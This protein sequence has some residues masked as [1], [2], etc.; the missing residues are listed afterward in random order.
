MLL[1]SVAHFSPARSI[2]ASILIAIGIGTLLLKLPFCHAGI[3]WINALF[4]ATSCLCIC[5]LSTVPFASFTSI[6]QCVLLM[7][8]QIGGLGLVTLT[9][10]LMSI[11]VNFGFTTQVIAGQLMELESWKD[12]KKFIFFIIGFTL[13]IEL[14]GAVGT[15]MSIYGDYSLPR[16]LFLSLFHAVSTFC[17]AGISLFPHGMITY[18]TH[19]IMLLFDS[20]IMIIAGLGFI[21]WY[22]FF[23]YGVLD[24]RKKRFHCSLQ[25][26]I[27]LYMTAFLILGAFL[28][29]WM[30]ER[31]NTLAHMSPTL[32]LINAFFNGIAIRGT[33]FSTVLIDQVQLPTL[34]LIMIT[35]FIGSAPGST[36]SGIKITTFAV[37]AAVILAAIAGRTNVSILGRSI[38]K[39]QM[40]KSIAIFAL[41]LFWVTVSTF[42]LLIIEEG[43]SFVDI[44]FESVSAFATLGLSTGVTPDLS[45]LGKLFIISNMIVGR[46]GA[47]GFILALCKRHEIPEFSYPEERIIVG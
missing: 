38:A 32:A 6:G 29:F 36:G 27:V 20:C 13:C 7:L 10:F 42:F 31:H 18:K 22:E 25:T 40:Y 17:D 45:T 33:G 23:K 26:K 3:S 28:L 39:D 46:I 2:L 35:S 1:R 47:L 16:S 37:F 11:F 8:I 9:F 14:L 15:F 24:G 34:L 41:S 12:I 44:L 4:T 43:W 30:L 5:G 21:T 19:Y